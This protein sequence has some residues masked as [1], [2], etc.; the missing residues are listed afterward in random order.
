MVDSVTPLVCFEKVL[1]G[2]LREDSS[3]LLESLFCDHVVL[4]ILSYKCLAEVKEDDLDPR[5][6]S[7]SKMLSWDKRL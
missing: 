1:A 6:H 2:T 3:Y 5:T 4:D 7:H